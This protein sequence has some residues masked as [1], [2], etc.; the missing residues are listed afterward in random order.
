VARPSRLHL[1]RLAN[2]LVLLLLRS[3]AHGLLS[4]RLA[5]LTYD[6]PR[7]GTRIIPLLYASTGRAVVALAARPEGKRWWRAFR[8]PTPAL[9]RVAGRDVA[10]NGR[11]LGPEEAPEALRRYLRRFPGAARTLGARSDASTSELRAVAE[12]VALVAFEPRRSS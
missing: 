10:V 5:L 9:L 8:A 2:P 4:S 1:L 3:P 7:G 12:T 11:L 6:R